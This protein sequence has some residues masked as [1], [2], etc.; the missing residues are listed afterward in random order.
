MKQE[1]QERDLMWK[2]SEEM[3]KDGMITDSNATK[4][5]SKMATET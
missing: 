5:P 2:P 1:R 3:F 4:R